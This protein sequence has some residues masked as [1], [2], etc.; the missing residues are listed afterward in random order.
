M[1]KSRL[2]VEEEAAASRQRVHGP[3]PSR[4]LRDSSGSAR[5]SWSSR[6]CWVRLLIVRPADRWHGAVEIGSI[7]GG[8]GPRQP[9]H[10]QLAEAGLVFTH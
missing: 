7:D 9:D 3:R 4:V 1:A 8:P 2:P 5:G 10:D 6:C